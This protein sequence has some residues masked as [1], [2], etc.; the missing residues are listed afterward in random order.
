MRQSGPKTQIVTDSGNVMKK[1]GRLAGYERGR[2]K[3]SSEIW[4]VDITEK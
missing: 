3:R 2:V 1:R 4:G